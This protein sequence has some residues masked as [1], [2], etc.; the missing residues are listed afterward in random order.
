MNLQMNPA[1]EHVMPIS[2]SAGLGRGRGNLLAG[3]L[4]VPAAAG[5]GNNGPGGPTATN[6]LRSFSNGPTQ[7]MA[8]WGAH[9]KATHKYN[10]EDMTRI[11][12]G[13]LYT[14]RLQLPAGVERDDN[15]L[16][17]AEGDVNDVLQQLDGVTD[18]EAAKAYIEYFS[19]HGTRR[20]GPTAAIGAAVAPVLGGVGSLSPGGNVGAL[21]AF[22]GGMVRPF[23]G[24]SSG[25]HSI[26]SSTGMI[27]DQQN[28]LQQPYSALTVPSQQQ[29]MPPQLAGHHH[30]PGGA[31]M[32]PTSSSMGMGGVPITP[33]VM[34]P[35]VNQFVYKD[36]QGQLQGPFSKDDIIEWYEGGFFPL[37][38]QV[39]A[40][41]DGPGAPFHNLSDMLRTWGAKLAAVQPPGFVPG[42]AQ[43]QQ[44]HRQP[45]MINAANALSGLS[46]VGAMQA[47]S[48]SATTAMSLLQNMQQQQQQQQHQPSS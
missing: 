13:L 47:S 38:L 7:T 31:L 9:S 44:Q 14:S 33:A 43:T 16:F 42:G 19:L 26:D 4:P 18:A 22:G 21:G 23:S 40:V 2:F 28:S 25:Q 10:R 29:P 1:S 46:L 20:G 39:R 24:G 32:A 6:F 45:N 12:R 3:P 8:Q 48:D 41:E 37:D 34:P 30:I 36:P 15:L 35:A 11:Y 5:S 17:L 27:L